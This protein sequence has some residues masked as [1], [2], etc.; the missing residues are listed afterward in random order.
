VGLLVLAGVFVLVRQHQLV[1]ATPETESAFFQ[2]YSLERTAKPF[3]SETQGSALGGGESAG[4]GERSATHQKDFDYHFVIKTE[5]WMPLM[6]ALAADVTKEFR[7][8]GAEVTD[9]SGDAR[10]GFR[11]EY[12]FGNTIGSAVILPLETPDRQQQRPKCMRGNEQTARLQVTRAMV[13]G[14]AGAHES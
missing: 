10:Q 14:K 7:Q 13:Q 9:V 11:F 12:V 3:F 6:M 8:A 5:N 2:R 1:Y 4:A